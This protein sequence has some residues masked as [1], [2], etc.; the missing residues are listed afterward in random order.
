MRPP[1]GWSAILLSAGLTGCASYNAMWNAQQ[2]AR[3][4]R[5]LEQ[6]GQT[7]DARAQW[8]LA[9]AKAR[10]LP[11]DKALVLRVEGLAYSGACRDAG[12]P[13]ARARANVT[14]PALRERIDLADAECALAAGDPSRADTALATP[15][16]SRDSERRSRA[17]YA[18]GRVAS[19][20]SE[21][22]AAAR[23]FSRS[24]VPGAAGRALVSQQRAL[25]ARATRTS[26]LQPIVS[27]LN[28]LLRTV[29]GT[30][31]AIHLVE[32]LTQLQAEPQTPGARFRRAEIARDSL[33]A[34]GLAGQLF[35][36][37]AATD[38]GSLFAPK[39]L[40]AALSLL[41][42]RRDSIVS[43][44]D[45]RYAASPYTRV[46][47]GEPSVAYAVAEDSLARELGIQVG[48]T[49]AAPATGRFDAPL[50]GP[51]GPKLP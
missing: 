40:I 16:A 37:M 44:L 21:Y 41:P 8:A 18:A 20:R 43:L 42:E 34:D 31:D 19:L 6:L 17:E 22:D 47:H 46:F 30:D 50:P 11:T 49:V 32:L 28:R 35:L 33:Q 27:E 7:S 10:T 36:E 4:A 38:R 24:R 9:A 26:D 39:A 45:S 51:R 2:H 29:G 13:L 15:L 48:R 25:I 5:R 1:P 23:H 3:D 14:D 12:E